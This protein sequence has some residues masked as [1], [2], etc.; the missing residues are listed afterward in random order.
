MS[1]VQ[2]PCN[3]FTD[4]LQNLINCR[5]SIIIINGTNNNSRLLKFCFK[6]CIA[7]K[8][9]DDDDYKYYSNTYDNVYDA[10]IVTQSL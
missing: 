6:T 5:F 1:A 2:R 3:E 9:V 7:M 8:F 10:V 4:M